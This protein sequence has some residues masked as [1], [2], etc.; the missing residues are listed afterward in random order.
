V[1]SNNILKEV[2]I[3]EKDFADLKNIIEEIKQIVIKGYFPAPTK[4]KQKCLDCTYKN[5]CC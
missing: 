3:E 2:K 5:I 4:S 1:R